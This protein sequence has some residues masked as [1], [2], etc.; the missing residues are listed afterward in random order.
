MQSGKVTDAQSE[1]RLRF[2]HE[3]CG[4]PDGDSAQVHPGTFVVVCCL[5]P[6]VAW[7]LDRVRYLTMLPDWLFNTS[8][9]SL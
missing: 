2:V 9:V 3:G 6:L 8:S 5:L 4:G 1:A 7:P